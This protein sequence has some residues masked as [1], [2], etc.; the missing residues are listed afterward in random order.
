MRIVGLLALFLSTQVFADV[1]VTLAP[2]LQLVAINEKVFNDNEID[3]TE[4]ELSPGEHK[5]IVRYADEFDDVAGEKVVSRNIIIVLKAEEG[6]LYRIKT[7]K[8]DRY[9]PAREF[10]N[11]PSYDVERIPL[12]S[13]GNIIKA[14]NDTADLQRT[15]HVVGR[16]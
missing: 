4:I 9:A 11:S 14:F 6:Y 5:L 1:S 15:K 12:D 13:S 2:Q 10:A 7:R 16:D 8:H 3:K